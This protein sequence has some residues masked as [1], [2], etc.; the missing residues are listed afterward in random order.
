MQWLY[1]GDEVF[2]ILHVFIVNKMR[3]ESGFQLM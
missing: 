1:M 2:Y 3:K